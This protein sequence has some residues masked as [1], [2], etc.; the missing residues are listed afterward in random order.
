MLDGGEFKP[1]QTFSGELIL[2]DSVID[3][4]HR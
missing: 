2:R 3:G 4:P 1:Q